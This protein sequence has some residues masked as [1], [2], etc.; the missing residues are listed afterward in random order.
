MPT[1]E[2]YVTI[3]AIAEHFSV[4]VSTVRVWIRTEQ[5]PKTTYIKVGTTYRFMLSEVDDA[6]RNSSPYDT[7]PESAQM[8]LDFDSDKV[9]FN[10][11]HVSDGEVAEPIKLYSEV[12]DI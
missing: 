1:P 2:P 9:A 12:E 8:E 6:L 5:I 7:E 4:S 3:D 11:E 10:G